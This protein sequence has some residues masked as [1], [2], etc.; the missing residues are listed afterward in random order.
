MKHHF[1]DQHSNLH[2]PVHAL[3]PRVKII[4]FFSFLFFVIFTPITQAQ[5]FV[6]YGTLIF[7]IILISRVPLKFVLKRSL[8][9]IPFVGFVAIGLPFLGGTGGSYN[10]GFFKITY[11]AFLIFLNLLVKSWLCVLAMITL[12]STTTFS[13]LLNGFQRLKVPKV[14]VMILSFM[15]RYIFV[16]GGELAQMRRARDART[17]NPSWTQS[18]KTAGCM[19]GT[20]FIRSYEKGERIYTAMRSRGF[21]GEI[22]LIHEFKARRADILFIAVFFSLLTLILVIA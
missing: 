8:V 5:K 3:D 22:R 11:S 10:F 21:N 16:L 14:F 7:S 13:K 2:S 6:L 12:T 1:L 17:F 20:L 9:I 15:Y 4:A 19:I 18:V